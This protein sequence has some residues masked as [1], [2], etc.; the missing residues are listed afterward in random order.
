MDE[1]ESLAQPNFK[2]LKTNQL[3][4]LH[5]DVRKERSACGRDRRQRIGDW[6][7]VPCL[8]ILLLAL[9]TLACG[10]GARATSGDY[11]TSI[12]HLPTLTRTPLPTLTA[13]PVST[14]VAVVEVPAE[15]SQTTDQSAEVSTLNSS[16]GSAVVPAQQQ[17]AGSNQTAN[18][19]APAVGNAQAGSAGAA[20]ANQGQVGEAVA[21]GPAAT[22]TAVPTPTAT[23]T[24]T[25]IPTETPTAVP[26]E[27]PTPTPLP[28]GWVF[29]NVKVSTA[30]DGGSPLLYGDVINNTGSP[31]DLYQ[32]TGN[33]F[34]QQGQPLPN[35]FTAD[36]WPIETVPQGDRVPFELSVFGIQSV[37]DFELGVDAAPS[38]ESPRQDFELSDL[39]QRIGD[40]DYCVNG[41]LRNPGSELRFYVTV[42][43]V[44]YDAQD[45]VIGFSDHYDY[46]PE[47]VVG[48]QT[49]DFDLCVDPLGQAVARHDLRAWGL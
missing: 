12:G 6:P 21:P 14:A 46:S 22:D 41:K 45:K 28:A 32:I 19:V 34:D 15:V 20:P 23:I 24:E 17:P 47:R 3:M 39:D 38:A 1:A 31:Q 44:L 27:A 25:P 30:Q 18:P 4:Q 5:K 11:S 48:D 33:F 36:Y 43:A 7:W 26:T 29:T 2:P 35:V 49:M 8:P 42:V 10:F 9:T 40:G 37:G 13:T 16:A